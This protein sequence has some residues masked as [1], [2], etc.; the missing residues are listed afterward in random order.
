MAP[1]CAES[2]DR[3]GCPQ[4]CDRA[5]FRGHPHGRFGPVQGY[6]D[7]LPPYGTAYRR[8]LPVAGSRRESGD[9]TPCRMTGLGIQPRVGWPEWLYTRG[10][11]PRPKVVR[12]VATGQ[13]SVDTHTGASALLASLVGARAATCT[14]QG[15]LAV[16]TTTGVPP[17]LIRKRNPLGP[18]RRPMPRVLGW[19]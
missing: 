5:A 19:S 16:R 12:S 8:A 10:C 15:Q 13:R 1:T 4:R 9:T 6:L 11:V 14:V 3:E 2:S 18:Y 17:S 7:C